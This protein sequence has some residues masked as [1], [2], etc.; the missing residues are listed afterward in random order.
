MSC[1]GGCS[2]SLRG[3]AQ[4]M[5]IDHS[6]TAE[7]KIAAGVGMNLNKHEALSFFQLVSAL[8]GGVAIPISDTESRTMAPWFSFEEGAEIVYVSY[9]IGFRAGIWYDFPFQEGYQFVSVRGGPF[10]VLN[11]KDLNHFEGTL[12][13]IGIEPF[14]GQ[15][16][17]DNIDGR[18]V[19]GISITYSFEAF[20]SIHIPR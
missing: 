9:P 3:G 20:T 19:G 2:L 4:S 18:F 8:D 6:A 11:K 5:I 10:F 17:G 15:G 12:T 13:G 1:T 14:I 16:I 7:G